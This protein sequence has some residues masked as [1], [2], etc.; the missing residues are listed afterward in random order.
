VSNRGRVAEWVSVGLLAGA[1]CLTLIS[2]Q[3]QASAHSDLRRARSI[4]EK[5]VSESDSRPPNLKQYKAVLETLSKSIEIRTEIDGRLE[6]LESIVRSL[7]SRRKDSEEIAEAGRAQLTAIAGTLG[8]A[9]G[10]ARR[11]VKELGGLGDRI[12]V[13]ARLSRLIAEELEELDHNL[14]PTIELPD[15]GILP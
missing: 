15:L 1:A 11:S 12:T 6:K 14:G 2:W 3:L 8:G 4:Q 9:S 7:D 10:A 13:S 5:E